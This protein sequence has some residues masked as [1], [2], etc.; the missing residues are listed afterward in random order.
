MEAFKLQT[1]LVYTLWRDH[2]A[3]RSCDVTRHDMT[4]VVHGTIVRIHTCIA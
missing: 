1:V 4:R 3:R 2:K